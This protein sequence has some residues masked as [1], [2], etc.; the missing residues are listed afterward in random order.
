MLVLTKK[1]FFG[2][3]TTNDKKFL[4]ENSQI[5]KMI[6]FQKRIF[7]FSY[8]NFLSFVVFHP[9]NW[10]FVRANILL[11]HHKKYLGR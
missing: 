5:Q 2:R 11:S 3:K 6:K 8:K 7:E 9:K 1:Q 10:F 4:F